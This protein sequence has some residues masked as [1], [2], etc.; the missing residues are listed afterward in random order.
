MCLRDSQNFSFLR[1]T[2]KFNSMSNFTHVLFP[3]LMCLSLFVFPELHTSIK[4]EN[5]SIFRT[6]FSVAHPHRESSAGDALHSDLRRA[7]ARAYARGRPER[8]H[9]HALRVLGSGRVASAGALVADALRRVHFRH[10]PA[11][12]RTQPRA[13]PPRAATRLIRARAHATRNFP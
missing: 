4:S 6:A 1:K 10:L 12:S 13:L 9:V 3:F 2:K 7:A 11:R 5:M 8:L